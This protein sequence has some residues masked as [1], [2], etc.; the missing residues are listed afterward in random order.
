MLLLE[1]VSTL[2]PYDL[3]DTPAG[4][5]PTTAAPTGVW[6]IEIATAGTLTAAGTAAAWHAYMGTAPIEWEDAVHAVLVSATV[7]QSESAHDPDT[8]VSDPYGAPSYTWS[9]AWASRRV[10]YVARYS[11]DAS[12]PR[13]VAEFGH[14]VAS[15]ASPISPLV[16]SS[17]V[18]QP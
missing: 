7:E 3:L 9:R 16:R 12:K 1:G 18:S 13:R 4:N 17:A 5:I 15:F 11:T 10:A 8:W 14:D 6:A 2:S